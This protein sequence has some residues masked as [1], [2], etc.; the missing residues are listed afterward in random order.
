MSQARKKPAEPVTL[1]VLL[2]ALDC[3]RSTLYRYMD[4]G[5]MPRPVFARRGRP[6]EWSRTRSN[7]PRRSASWWSKA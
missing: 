5:L 3:G 4:Q 1:E 7:A 2:E 6:A